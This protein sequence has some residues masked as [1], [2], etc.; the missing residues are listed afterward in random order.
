MAYNVKGDN[1]NLF[2]IERYIQKIKKEDI[3]NYAISQEI[4]LTP[5]ELDI[6][7]NYLKNKYKLFLSNPQI[8]PELLSEIKSKVNPKVASKLNELYEQYKYKL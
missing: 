1:M 7:Y 4:T 6:I 2:F 5:N 3:Y 8:R